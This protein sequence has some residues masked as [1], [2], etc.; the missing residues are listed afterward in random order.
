MTL[1]ISVGLAVVLA[2]S[3]LLFV[4]VT[5]VCWRTGMLD[6]DGMGIGSLFTALFYVGGWLVPSL[7][8]ALA[9][10][11]WGRPA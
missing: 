2:L 11:L 7:V 9:W 4:L 5:L 10:A 1:T 6:D 8:A 3:A